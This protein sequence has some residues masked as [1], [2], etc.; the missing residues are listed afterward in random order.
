MS[1]R[2]IMVLICHRHKLLDPISRF[3]G[4][5]FLIAVTVNSS[6]LGC[7]SGGSPKFR[8]KVLPPYSGSQSK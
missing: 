6:L 4:F 1:K 2:L 7:E 8:M 5:E 3:V